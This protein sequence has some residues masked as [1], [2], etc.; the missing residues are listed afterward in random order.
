MLTCRDVRPDDTSTDFAAWDAR[1]GADAGHGRGDGAAPRIGDGYYNVQRRC[2]GSS[3]TCCA[4]RSRPPR[5]AEQAFAVYAAYV[6]SCC[7]V[8]SNTDM[9][10]RS[11]R[12]E[13]SN[14]LYACR[15]A[16]QHERWSDRKNSLGPESALDEARALGGGER[17]VA[18][19]EAEVTDGTRSR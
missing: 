18:D 6:R 19:L 1:T 4:R 17:L 3:R 16:R 11:L 5:V 13:E 7:D 9:A 14:L 12:A 2:R 8:T 15:P 10:M